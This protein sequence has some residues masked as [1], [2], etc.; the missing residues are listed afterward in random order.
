MVCD[1]RR[2]VLQEE[3]LH[4]FLEHGADPSARLNYRPFSSTALDSAAAFGTIDLVKLLLQHGASLSNSTPLQSAAMSP[5]EDA[6]RIPML[7]YLLG[8]TSLDINAGDKD[9]V[10]IHYQVGPPINAA[11]KKPHMQ[12]VRWLLGRG[13]V[14]NIGAIH[15]G[16]RL[17]RY[18]GMEEPLKA[19]EEA[20]REMGLEDVPEYD[21]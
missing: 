10:G 1:T 6:D 5:L 14:P 21:L 3:L 16:R 8:L 4:W 2:V 9:I 17:K 13:A 12:R 15:Q 20:R 11:L 18:Q 7:E 19:L